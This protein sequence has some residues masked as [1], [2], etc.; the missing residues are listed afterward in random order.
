MFEKAARQKLRFETSKGL[1]TIEDLWDLPLSG[2]GVNLDRIAIGLSKQLKEET[3]ESF[4]VKAKR[5]SE[6][7]QLKFDIVKHIIDVRLAEAEEAKAKAETKDKKDRLLTL[8][9]KKQDEQLEGKS[10]DELKAM[11]ETL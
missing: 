1:L 11:V 3:T 9:A 7:L 8:I 5:T 4:V 6:V 2:N 10:L